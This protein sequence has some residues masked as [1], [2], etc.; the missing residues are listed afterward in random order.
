MNN[1]KKMIKFIIMKICKHRFVT[2]KFLGI[3]TSEVWHTHVI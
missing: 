3:D 2:R 1:I